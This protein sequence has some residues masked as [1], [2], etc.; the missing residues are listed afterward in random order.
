MDFVKAHEQDAVVA[1][2]IPGA[3]GRVGGLPFKVDLAAP[4]LLF[5][6]EVAGDGFDAAVHQL[7]VGRLPL[8][9]VL[10][11]EEHEGIGRRR[12]RL[13]GRRD[14]SD[15]F[16]GGAVGIMHPETAPGE[17]R[18]VAVAIDAR[19]VFGVDQVFRGNRGGRQG[20]QETKGEGECS[21]HARDGK[22]SVRE[23]NNNR[24]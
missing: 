10:A 1:A 4:E 6:G 17:H 15:A 8:G 18:G 11:V 16:G 20:N 13:R 22:R 24:R 3:A 7:P 21:F 14:G 23:D 9:E 2:V 19:A 12:G 5:G